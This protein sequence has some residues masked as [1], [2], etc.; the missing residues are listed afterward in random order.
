MNIY[1][2]YFPSFVPNIKELISKLSY[3]NS[4]SIDYIWLS[5]FYISGNKDGGYDIIDYYNINPIIGNHND[6]D[7]LI[8][9]A[10]KY[11]IKIMIDMVLNHTSF[12]HNWFKDSIKKNGKDDWYIWVD[13]IVDNWKS[14]FEKSPWTW[15][16]KKKTILLSLLLQRTT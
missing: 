14:E 4:L 7:Q 15:N 10:Q 2:C 5:P 6:F 12:H 16:E 11:N 3:L 13:H 9:E 8:L 1:Q